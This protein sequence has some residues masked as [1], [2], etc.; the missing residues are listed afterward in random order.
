MKVPRTAI[1]ILAQGIALIG[2]GAYGHWGLGGVNGARTCIVCGVASF[3][4]A[5]LVVESSNRRAANS[6]WSDAL[7]RL[8]KNRMAVA[9]GIAFYVIV[10]FSFLGPTL[11]RL[12]AGLDGIEPNV[13]L[14]ATPPSAEHWMG[15]DPL[16]R[17]LMVRIMEGG[18]WAILAGFAATSVALC[19][20]VIWGAV[21]GYLGGKI[22]EIMMR[23]VDVLYAFP[24]IV[25]VIVIMTVL[26]TK[27]LVVLFALIGGISWLTMSRIVRGQVMSLRNREFIEAARCL[28]ASTPRIVFRHIVPNTLGPVIVYATL[29][30]PSVMLTEAFLS[31]LGLGVQA[32]HASWGTL[33]TE[34][35]SQI[36]VNP[37][38]L[39]FPG[40]MMGV[41]IFALNFLGEGLRDALDPQ[42]RKD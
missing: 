41:T 28:G 15:T 35:A 33:V 38:T 16:G 6:L 23:Q 10:L 5:W 17:D 9:C 12:I 8:R 19:I 30:L 40:L 37:W 31:F 4:L 18:Q 34:G 36:A 1:F 24:T 22:D 3:F 39:I 26:D 32:P 2:F 27:S 13:V 7:R 20:G 29:S 11:A 25:F 14:K 42:M 21:A